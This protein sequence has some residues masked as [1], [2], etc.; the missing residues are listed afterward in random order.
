MH[1]KINNFLFKILLWSNHIGVCCCFLK[2]DD[3]IIGYD[4]F[5]GQG[6]LMI[7]N[8]YPGW[9]QETVTECSAEE[10]CGDVTTY[11]GQLKPSQKSPNP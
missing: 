5:G 10:S 4:G 3:R 2:L 1:K 11:V 7:P 9:I 8:V 6:I